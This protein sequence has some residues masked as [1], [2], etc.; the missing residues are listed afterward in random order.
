M[1]VCRGKKGAVTAGMTAA[2]RLSDM[3]KESVPA[4]TVGLGGALVV[5]E[6]GE[7]GR[8]D[9]DVEVVALVG[10]YGDNGRTHGEAVEVA[11][12]VEVHV[13]KFVGLEI[14]GGR[15]GEFPV[16]GRADISRET[17]VLGNLAV[18]FHLFVVEIAI[19]VID[20]VVDAQAPGH[21][22]SCLCA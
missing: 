2:A 4:D 7:E 13:G 19:A 20:G 11:G 12:D 10:A 17:Q 14:V 18:V 15:G 5:F 16:L 6:V 8:L 21:T 9:G 3:G 1:S 22:P